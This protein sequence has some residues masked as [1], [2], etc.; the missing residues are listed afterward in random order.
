[1]GWASPSGMFQSILRLA[2][3]WVILP[4][5][6]HSLAVPGDGDRQEGGPVARFCCLL[7]SVDIASALLWLVRMWTPQVWL[8]PWCPRPRESV[9][10]KALLLCICSTRPTAPGSGS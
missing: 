8:C 7:R 9:S 4:S 1:M 6:Q 5:P 10:Q 2:D 3:H